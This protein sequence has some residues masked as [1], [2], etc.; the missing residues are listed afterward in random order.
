MN[1]P[2]PG[3]QPPSVHRPLAIALTS[4]LGATVAPLHAS[5]HPPRPA[6]SIPV[7]NCNDDGAGSLRD[8]V[9][10]AV[11]GDTVDLGGLSC[12]TITL[13]SGAIEIPQ[14]DLAVKYIGSGTHPTIDGGGLQRVFHHTGA[15]TLEIDGLTV[16]HGKYAGDPALGGCIFSNGDVYLLGTT[17]NACQARGTGGTT[18][19]AKGGGVFAQGMI[20]TLESRITGNV[21]STTQSAVLA[22]GGGLFSG[23]GLAVSDSVI[24][25]NQTSPYE[26][27]LGTGGGALAIGDSVVSGSAVYGNQADTGGGLALFG[28]S[29]Q[30]VDSTISTNNS[31]SSALLFDAGTSTLSNSTVAFNTAG[32]FTAGVASSYALALYSSIVADNRMFGGGA[33]QDLNAATVLGSHNLIVSSTNVPPGSLN[34]DPALLPLAANGGF[35]PTHALSPQSPAIDQGDAQGLTTDQRGT[36]YA[37]VVGLAADIGAFERQGAQDGDYIFVDGFDP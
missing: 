17:V 13:T 36:G 30:V 31:G 6:A 3:M 8:A 7:T 37:R 4:L 1:R 34:D 9:A 11:S 19:G 18:Q 10:H 2:H 33:T 16:T 20:R 21:A 23:T 14:D 12:S 35:A 28:N 22:W 32:A 26:P 25:G 29:A 27:G 15:G 5:T 24:S